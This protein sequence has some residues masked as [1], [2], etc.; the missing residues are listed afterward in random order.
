MSIIE[1]Y[2]RKF[3]RYSNEEESGDID[4]NLD[5]LEDERF[6][7]EF[8]SEFNELEEERDELFESYDPDD[9]R[10][11]TISADDL[12][13]DYKILSSKLNSLMKIKLKKNN[14]NRNT[15]N[16]IEEEEDEEDDEVYC[17]Y[18]ISENKCMRQFGDYRNDFFDKLCAYNERTRRCNK[19]KDFKICGFDKST[20]RCNTK[21]KNR[22]RHNSCKIKTINGRRLCKKRTLGGSGLGDLSAASSILDL[23]D[24]TTTVHGVCPIFDLDNRRIIYKCRFHDINL[25]IKV[26]NNPKYINPYLFEI[27]LYN[28]LE[29]IGFPTVEY[30]GSKL[31]VVPNQATETLS[32]EFDDA[33]NMLVQLPNKFKIAAT[34]DHNDLKQ[35]IKQYK[36]SANVNILSHDE[37]INE[38]YSLYYNSSFNYLAMITRWSDEYITLSDYISRHSEE[39]NFYKNISIIIEKV[40]TQLRLLNDHGIFHGDV[41]PDNILV[42]YHMN[43]KI[44]DFD[45]SGHY[46][47][48][49]GVINLDSAASGIHLLTYELLPID[50]KLKLDKLKKESG[51]DSAIIDESYKLGMIHK[52]FLNIFLTSPDNIINIMNYIYFI[53]VYRLWVSTLGVISNKN[54]KTIVQL[55]S[56]FSALINIV[57]ENRY[58][59]KINLFEDILDEIIETSSELEESEQ[60][61]ELIKIKL[62]TSLYGIDLSLDIKTNDIFMCSKLTLNIFSSLCNSNGIKKDGHITELY[63]LFD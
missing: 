15:E 29:E 63:R 31:L 30:Y 33:T 7:D 55:K 5:S 57:P 53:D 62:A 56:I 39:K 43:V 2:G 34:Y 40:L 61:F 24:Q 26:T 51:C 9:E 22:I 32:L 49:G 1:V 20:K 36:P 21:F 14:K 28:K 6:Y 38:V 8:V 44:F 47:M 3:D 42:N 41:K 16:I 13:S 23:H 45:R 35:L 59:F 27:R 19:S 37:C 46:R 4:L 50:D 17:S 10:D 25:A 11:W 48:M 52:R 60:H 58:R 18:D 54:D 12:L